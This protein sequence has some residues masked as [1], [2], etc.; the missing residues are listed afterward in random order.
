[1]QKVIKPIFLI[2]VKFVIIALFV[3][4]CNDLLVI[5]KKRPKSY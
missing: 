1:M 4:L 2:Y 5:V 3:I